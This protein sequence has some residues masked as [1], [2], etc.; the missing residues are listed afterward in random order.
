MAKAPQPITENIAPSS[1]TADL[2]DLGEIFK[3]IS[4][5]TGYYTG[6]YYESDKNNG[7]SALNKFGIQFKE[8]S[9]GDT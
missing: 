8:P 4:D 2:D 9:A 1:A 3:A 7:V 6:A 5:I